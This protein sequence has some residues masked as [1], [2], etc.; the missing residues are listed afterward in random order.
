M[1]RK[2]RFVVNFSKFDK[3]GFLSKA[4]SAN[5]GIAGN[6]DF[7]RAPVTHAQFS[8]AYQRM[9]DA[10]PAAV[11][12]NIN[13]QRAFRPLRKAVEDMMTSL[14]TFAQGTIGNNPERMAASGLPLTR[15]PSAR[16]GDI[17][18]SVKGAKLEPGTESGKIKV[19]AKS[20]QAA[21]GIVVEERQADRS[22]KEIAKVTGFKINLNGFSPDDVVVVQIR[23]WNNEGTGPRMVRPLA[24]V[25]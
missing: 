9:V 14:A 8:E 13:G 19:S 17:N 7:E 25:V 16:P 6:P 10:A 5:K 21:V 20:I 11:R 18:L 24:I 15:E 2:Q 3:A 22:Y 23:Y 1:T 4:D 12:S